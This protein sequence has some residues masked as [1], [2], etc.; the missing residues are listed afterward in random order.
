MKR[1]CTDSGKGIYLASNILTCRISVVLKMQEIS[2]CKICKEPINN[3]VCID[4]L[5]KDVTGWLP[6]DVSKEFSEFNMTLLKTFEYGRHKKLTRHHMVCGA[7]SMNS[8]CLYCYVNEVFQWLID[9]NFD[10]AISF[11]KVFSFGMNREYFDNIPFSHANPI[12]ETEITRTEIGICD[13]CGEYSNELR[14]VNGEWTC[15]AC[16]DLYGMPG[17]GH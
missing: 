1:G 3:F 2:I 4:C 6:P 12:T 17:N 15:E 10:V 14:M 8:I 13:M 9:V 7:K 16:G 5:S 11:S